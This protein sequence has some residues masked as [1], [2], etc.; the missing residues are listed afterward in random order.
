MTFKHNII[1]TLARSLTGPARQAPPQ[2]LGTLS[3]PELRR[4]VAEMVG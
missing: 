1:E 3:L 2:P 4:A